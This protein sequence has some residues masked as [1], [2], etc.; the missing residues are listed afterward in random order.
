MKNEVRK[1][2]ENYEYIFKNLDENVVNR[3]VHLKTK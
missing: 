1:K 2:K 3:I